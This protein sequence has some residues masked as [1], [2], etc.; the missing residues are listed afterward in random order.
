MAT[1][2]YVDSRFRQY[3][4]RVDDAIRAA[5]DQTAGR[6]AGTAR[7]LAS[8]RGGLEHTIFRTPVGRTR[9][10]FSVSVVSALPGLY[11]ERGTLRKLGAKGSARGRKAG[12][13]G[14]RGVKPLRFLVHALR[15]N[16]AGLVDSLRRRL[17]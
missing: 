8:P 6:V 12:G 11:Q 5:L 17:S 15:E 7:Q 13:T 14:G 4:E 1:R 16:R 3:G 2:V 10:G 9:R